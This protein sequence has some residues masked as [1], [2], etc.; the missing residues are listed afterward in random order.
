MTQVLACVVCARPADALLT[1]GLYAGVLVLALVVVT[2]VA[3]LARG[4]VA[5]VRADTAANPVVGREA[6]S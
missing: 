2:V 4:V 3:A 1:S 5:V 6:Q